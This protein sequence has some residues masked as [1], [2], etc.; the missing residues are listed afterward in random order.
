M[1]PK[2]EKSVA[3]LASANTRQLMGIAKEQIKAI[4]FF[5]M[6]SPNC[7]GVVEDF[8]KSI[9]AENRLLC[10]LPV[11]EECIDGSELMGKAVENVMKRHLQHE[12]KDSKAESAKKIKL[13]LIGYTLKKNSFLESLLKEVKTS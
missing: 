5:E 3:D 10:L 2:I 13:F 6:N 12:A 4:L 8:L 11:F 7:E 9:L 1:N